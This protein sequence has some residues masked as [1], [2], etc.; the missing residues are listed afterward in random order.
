MIETSQS[1]LTP[2][3]VCPLLTMHCL[4]QIHAVRCKGR[5]SHQMA[6]ITNNKG[7]LEFSDAIFIAL[8]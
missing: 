4:G 8:C 1:P 7:W 2:F 3:S 6:F 5:M